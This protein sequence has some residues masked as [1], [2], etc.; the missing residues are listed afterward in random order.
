MTWNLS[1]LHYLNLH[2]SL[3]VYVNGVNKTLKTPNIKLQHDYNLS[4]EHKLNGCLPDSV[5]KRWTLQ[6]WDW[7]QRWCIGLHY[8]G[9]P[10]GN[11]VSMNY[12]SRTGRKYAW[13]VE[14]ALQTYSLC[15]KLRYAHTLYIAS[16]E[17]LLSYFKVNHRYSTSAE[18]RWVREVLSGNGVFCLSGRGDPQIER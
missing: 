3:F 7:R 11:W 12:F 17:Q 2:T 14:P 5:N 10:K 1:D 4:G 16:P 15:H 13:H 9:A 8:L 6:S 18:S